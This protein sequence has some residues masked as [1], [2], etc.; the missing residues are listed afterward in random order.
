M[1]PLLFISC[2][3]FTEE[4][5]WT[6]V[7]QAKMNSN[8]DSTMQ[9]SQRI[10]KEYPQGRYSGWAQFA[11]AESHRFKNQNREALENYKLFIEKY[12]GMQPSAVSLFLVGYIYSNNLLVYDSAKIYYEQFMIKYPS[13]DLAPTVLLELQTLGK[14]PQEVLNA[15]EQALK[16]MTKK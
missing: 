13:H 12:P 2:G 15:Q 16:Q 4:E 3:G 6:K 8:W 1:F 11:I 5:L 9:V 14:S 10:L 7:E